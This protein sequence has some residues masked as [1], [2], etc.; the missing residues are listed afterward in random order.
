[1]ANKFKE[2]DTV[3]LISP[4]RSKILKGK[5][6]RHG[7]KPSDFEDVVPSYFV[8]IE[9]MNGFTSCEW[10]P[11]D[12]LFPSVDDA[13]E[14]LKSYVGRNNHLVIGGKVYAN[15]NGKTLGSIIKCINNKVCPTMYHLKIEGHN[16][17]DPVVDR[18]QIFLSEEDAKM[19]LLGNYMD[20]DYFE[21]V[22]YNNTHACI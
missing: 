14:R 19:S 4:D 11:E 15:I 3:F 22:N 9:R 16:G 18:S 20:L 13:Y 10:I 2:E 8:R 7:F 17:N 5:V 6:F 21:D 1:M 12:D